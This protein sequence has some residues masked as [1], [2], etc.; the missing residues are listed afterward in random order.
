MSSSLAAATK[1]RALVSRSIDGSGWLLNVVDP[2]N[3]PNRGDKS[4]EGQAFVLCLEAAYRDYQ[5]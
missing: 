2:W 4:A 1:A 5:D 3:Y